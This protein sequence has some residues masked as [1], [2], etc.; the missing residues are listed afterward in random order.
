MSKVPFYVINLKSAH[1]RRKN[2]RQQ[3]AEIGLKARIVP[4]YD[5]HDENFPFFLYRELAGQWWDDYERFKPG[6]FGCYLSHAKCWLK[7]ARGNAPYGVIM[8][9]DIKLN[10]QSFESLFLQ[11]DSMSFDVIYINRRMHNWTTRAE[12][13]DTD[14]FC[15]VAPL[16]YRL[17][18][19]GTYSKNVPAP[20]TDG[21]IVSKNGAYKLLYMMRSRKI[22]MGIDYAMAL[23]TLSQEE[24]DSLKAVPDDKLPFSVRCL[25]RNETCQ[26][27]SE[28]PV[29]IDSY[30]YKQCMVS[31][32]HSMPST[33]RHNTFRSN[34]LFNTQ[35]S[36]FW[37]GRVFRDPLT[38]HIRNSS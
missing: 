17:I 33:I 12:T 21:Y 16:L 6:A 3:F 25:L 35:P 24:I 11:I 10:S 1:D 27:K 37:R 30:I 28:T 18:L 13:H 36:S 22:S 26:L 32:I 8:E 5:C 7:I 34:K 29:C 14:A 9:D 31:T 20:G 23:N 38:S 15:R 4:A 19:D 2:I